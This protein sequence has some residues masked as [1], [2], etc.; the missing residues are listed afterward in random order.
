M[1]SWIS[2][3]LTSM[4]RRLRLAA[5][6]TS[7]RRCESRAVLF[8]AARVARDRGARM[9]SVRWLHQTCWLRQHAPVHESWDGA[10]RRRWSWAWGKAER[11]REAAADE[12]A[13]PCSSGRLSMPHG[14]THT[15]REYTRL[16]KATGVPHS[17]HHTRR[18]TLRELLCIGAAAGTRREDTCRAEKRNGA[19]GNRTPVP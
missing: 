7:G 8:R 17:A 4:S 18:I 2:R 9:R 10:A 15:A 1:G 13:H 16:C 12:H 6:T 14:W 5:D 3:T 11:L 19:G